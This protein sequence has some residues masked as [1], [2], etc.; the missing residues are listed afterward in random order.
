M[1]TYLIIEERNA[2]DE[3]VAYQKYDI[4][5]PQ[6]I[7]LVPLGANTALQIAWIEDLQTY[8]RR[9][10]LDPR[11]LEPETTIGVVPV[12][13]PYRPRDYSDEPL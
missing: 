3:L 5:E 1:S 8:Y 9:I 12:P 4:T 7:S 2:D 11:W 6:D 13:G 10:D